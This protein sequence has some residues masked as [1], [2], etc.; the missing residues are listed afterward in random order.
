MI[1]HVKSRAPKPS[2]RG[3]ACIFLVVQD[4]LLVHLT[5][6]LRS[7]GTY[8]CRSCLKNLGVI[9]WPF[10]LY[11]HSLNPEKFPKSRI[12]ADF[13][14]SAGS[15][16]KPQKNRI[17]NGLGQNAPEWKT[18]MSNHASYRVSHTHWKR[19]SHLW[20]LLRRY[21]VT[22]NNFLWQI[23]SKWPKIT[24]IWYFRLKILNLNHFMSLWRK[25][26][27][28]KLFLATK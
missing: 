23:P 10:I 11:A 20:V 28:K 19:V 15:P 4:V 14:W 1:S 13:W 25:L 8:A 26:F 27:H 17:K 3:V 9:G 18:M 24:K 5:N 2:V 21:L 12:F 16:L 7:E 6:H 22:R